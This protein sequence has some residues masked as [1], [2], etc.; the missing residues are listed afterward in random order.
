MYGKCLDKSYNKNDYLTNKYKNQTTT[1]K[2]DP[3]YISKKLTIS[4]WGEKRKRQ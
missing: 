1:T 2:N 3:T 4:S